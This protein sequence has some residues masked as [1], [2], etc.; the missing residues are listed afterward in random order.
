MD[1][2]GLTRPRL[3]WQLEIF[4]AEGKVALEQIN[5]RSSMPYPYE[6]EEPS[7]SRTS[8]IPSLPGSPCVKESGHMPEAFSLFPPC[9][10]GLRWR[11]EKS[12]IPDQQINPP[13][14]DP[15]PS[16]GEGT[17]GTSGYFLD[18]PS[19]LQNVGEGQDERGISH[20][21]L[22][23]LAIPDFS[24]QE[25]LKLEE[26]FLD[27]SV[28]AHPLVLY[29]RLWEGKGVIEAKKISDY[30]GKRVKLAG[31][32][33]TSQR[34][35]TVKGEYMKFVT[36]EDLTASY[37]VTFFPKAY[38]RCGQVLLNG[39]GPYLVSGLVEDDGGCLTLTADSLTFLM[40]KTTYP[41]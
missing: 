15:L 35:R 16:R 4:K 25:K 31:W 26:E 18:I 9:E 29:R 28:T 21:I 11:G 1:C 23:A 39:Q 19:P 13:H 24:W 30:V 34:T 7:P 2:F 38:R 40:K 36:M 10:E 3:L 32:I 12:K 6:E 5:P 8:T 41:G 14:P 22:T 17:K 20:E 37:E 33:I 27:F